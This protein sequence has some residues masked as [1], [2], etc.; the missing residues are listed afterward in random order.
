MLVLDTNLK[1]RATGQYFGFDLNSMVKFNGKYLGASGSGL[2]SIGEV[3]TEFSAYFITA[4]MDFGINNDKRLRYVY[5]SLESASNLTLTINTEKVAAID[6]TV[7]VSGSGQQDVRV[8][9]SREL[10]GRFWTFKISGTADFSVD[11]IKVLPIVRG[12]HV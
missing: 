3:D 12:F 8:P 9:I 1:N 7:T 6:Y 4:T 11:E 2:F 5:L 10:Y